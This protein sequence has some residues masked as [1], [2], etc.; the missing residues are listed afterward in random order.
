[1]NEAAGETD[2]VVGYFLGV[3]PCLSET[4]IQREVTALR[5]QGMTLLVFAHREAD[6]DL[7]G[8]EERRLARETIYLPPRTGWMIPLLRRLFWHPARTLAAVSFLRTR[9][10]TLFVGLTSTQQLLAKALSLVEALE[11]CGVQ[12]LHSPWA[13][14]D[15]AV[16]RLAAEFLSIPCSLEA[17]ASDLYKKNCL[18][19]LDERLSESSFVLTNSDYNVATI[20]RRF[21]DAR[22]VPVH[23]AYEGVEVSSLRPEPPRAGSLEPARIVCVARMTE[24]KGLSYLLEA[25]RLLRDRGCAF[26]CDIVGGRVDSEAPYADAILAQCRELEL[27]AEVRFVGPLPFGEVLE[28]YRWADL[29]V[30][31]AIRSSDGRRDITPNS[32]IEALAMGVPVVSTRSGAIEELVD[33]GE[34]GLLVPPADARSFADAMQRLI[35]DHD[36]RRRMAHRARETAALRFDIDR[37]VQTHAALFRKSI[38]GELPSRPMPPDTDGRIGCE[39]VRMSPAKN[40]GGITVAMPAY[41]AGRFIRRALDSVLSQE[42]VDLEVIVVDDASSDDTVAAARAVNDPRCRVLR[43][44]SRR[45]IGH[46]HNRIL[47]ESRFEIISHVDADDWIRQGAL[48]KLRRALEDD[49]EIGLAHCYYLDVDEN[50]STTIE[51]FRQRRAWFRRD[52]PVD[53]NYREALRQSPS[54]ANHL[55]TYRRSTLRALGGFDE[56]LSFGID[57]DMALRILE[58]ADIHLVPEFLYVRRLHSHNTTESLRLKRYR[59][60]LQQYRIRRSLLRRGRITYWSDAHFDPDGFLLREWR[61]FW[62]RIR[63]NR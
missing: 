38:R 39:M 45:G 7:L 23:R 24:P 34:T 43:N 29:C 15:A 56:K 13:F 46:C 62:A 32:L 50:G 41:N 20:E 54:Y 47:R 2:G 11:R 22:R 36:L 10:R 3:F 19:G 6:Q 28:K 44:T 35:E 8:P 55:R 16:A 21:G 18:P 27:E 42:G 63:P 12:H 14:E 49:P 4:F 1:M 40:E 59:M 57:Y 33:H 52:R 37:N 58:H 17:R 26:R 48:S 25:A 53:L 30:L 61:D 5:R 51:A 31:A 60:W 9:R